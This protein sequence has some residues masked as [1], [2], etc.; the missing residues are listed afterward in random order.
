MF[1]VDELTKICR[2]TRCGDVCSKFLKVRSPK[3]MQSNIIRV[4]GA[5]KCQECNSMYN[6][7]D[8]GARNIYKIAFNSIN[9][10]E[11]PSYLSRSIP[12]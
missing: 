5:L 11:R 1:S 4:R 3:P 9:S 8:N 12:A 10:K 6:R 2:Y 7:D